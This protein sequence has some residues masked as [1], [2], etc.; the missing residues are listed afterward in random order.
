MDLTGL[1]IYLVP[2]VPDTQ[3]WVGSCAGTAPN[4][5]GR[6]CLKESWNGKVEREGGASC[7]GA[8]C[9]MH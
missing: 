5:R 4:H 6:C 7:D 8:F 1:I 3:V 9:V 2:L